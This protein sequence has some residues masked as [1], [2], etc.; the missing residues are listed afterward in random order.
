MSNVS[1]ISKWG[2]GIGVHISNIR[3]KGSI[4]RGTNGPSSGIVPMLKVYNEIARYVN[5]G[6][7]RKGSFAIYLEPH[8][9]DLMDFLEL[10]NT[11]V[12]TERTRDLFLALWISDLF[13]KQVK[14]GSDW[15]FLCLMNVLD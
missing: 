9:P 15:Y 13:M 5:Q 3:A 2:G 11:G 4:I 8:H 6:G 12:E 1:Q 14:K 10:E 7:K